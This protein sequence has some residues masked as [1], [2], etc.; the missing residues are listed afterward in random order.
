M[1]HLLALGNT[2]REDAEGD[3]RSEHKDLNEAKVGQEKL[4]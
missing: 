3:K 1:Q 4:L 2:D